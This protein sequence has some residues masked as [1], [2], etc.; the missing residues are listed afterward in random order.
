MRKS[1]TVIVIG[2]ILAMMI[3][4]SGCAPPYIKARSP[5]QYCGKL[6]DEIDSRTIELAEW[7]PIVYKIDAKVLPLKAYQMDTDM[8]NMQRW[9]A[10][11]KQL[12]SQD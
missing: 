6:Q 12:H 3:L 10:H 5:K 2:F 4:Q 8:T 11:W 1:R 9:K 7:Q